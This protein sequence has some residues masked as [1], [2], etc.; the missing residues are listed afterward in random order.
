MNETQ[1]DPPED[2]PDLTES[3][4]PGI[5][6][7]QP[8]APSHSIFIGPDGLRAGWRFAAYVISVI[9]LLLLISAVTP[10]L[11]HL[12][13]HQT[14]PLWFF[15]VREVGLLIAAV[16][17]AWI[18]S[19]YENRKLGD[20]GLPS[21]SAFS[22]N[23]WHGVIWGICAIT[24]LLA[25]MRGLGGFFFGGLALHGDRI[26]EFAVFWAVLFLIV[27]FFEE[28][29]MRGYSQYTLA[30]GIGFWPAAG[31]L[32]F[33]FGAIHMSNPG[34][35][36]AGAFA[37]ALIGLFWCLTLQRTGTLWFAVG[38]H[39]S[40]DWGE[41]FLY[42]VPDSGQ[43]A[44][45]HLLSSSFHGPRWLTGGSVGPEGSALVFV[46]IALMWV[47][48]DRLH[49][50]SVYPISRAREDDPRIRATSQL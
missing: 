24:V 45:G 43:V 26:I 13:R 9:C 12:Q 28:F 10:R 23:F 18:L 15:L 35:A 7:P 31:L 34:E 37:A 47:L 17:P 36:W 3:Q 19:R 25:V 41:S 39:A 30:Q 38:M 48:F 14:P 20:Y 2:S 32:S 27:G 50:R 44:P 16:A 29:L 40:W 42:S 8:A 46:L 6:E 21:R 49:P 1:Q 22:R 11:M 4:V 33:L 5:T